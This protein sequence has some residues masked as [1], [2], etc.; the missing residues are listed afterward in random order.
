MDI[1]T[2][3]WESLLRFGM[4]LLVTVLLMAGCATGKID[5]APGVPEFHL[6]TTTAAHR[7]ICLRTTI[8]ASL[9]RVARV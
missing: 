9:K 7:S 5:L 6:A 2:A 4:A 1:F 8:L 3:H